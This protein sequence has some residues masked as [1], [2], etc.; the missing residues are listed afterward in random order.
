MEWLADACSRAPRTSHARSHH[1]LRAC[2]LALAA[3]TLGLTLGAPSAMA[4][5][6]KLPTTKTVRGVVLD[7]SGNGIGGAAVEMTNL[8][9][10]TKTAIFAD[11]GGRFMF[12]GL[13]TFDDYQFRATYQGKTSEI[14]KVTSYDNRLRV[15]VNLHIPP[16]KD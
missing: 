9:T 12:A 11:T 6:K 2:A 1:V 14:R 7:A 5:K 3:A 15:Q 16:P 10:G 13:K 4:R 8:S